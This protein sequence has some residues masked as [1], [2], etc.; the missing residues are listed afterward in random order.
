[1]SLNSDTIKE[2]IVIC[3]QKWKGPKEA[4]IYGKTTKFV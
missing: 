3:V 4:K 2:S 1:M